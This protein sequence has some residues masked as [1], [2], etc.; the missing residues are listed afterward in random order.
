MSANSPLYVSSPMLPSL[1]EFHGMLESIWDSKYVTNHG[2]IH[3]QLEAKLREHLKVPTAMLF[4]NA[5]IG[6]VSALKMF[7]FDVGSEI[8]TTPL[9]FAATPHAIA[10]NGL[11]P[12]FADV[13][14]QSMTL[15][16]ASV[17]RAITNKTCAIVAVHVYGNVCNL[18]ALQEI[19]NEYGLRLIYDAAHAFGVEVNGRGIGT[20][21]DASVF[22]FHA[23][24]LFNTIEGGAIT[25]PIEADTSKIYML[26]NFGIKNEEEVIDIGLN[27]KM[28]ELQAAI[29]LLNLEIYKKEVFSRSQLREKYNSFLSKKNGISIQEKQ[30]G[31][32]P[33]EQYYPIKIDP[34]IFGSSRDDIYNKLKD[35][36]IFARKYFHPICTDF[37]PYKG[38]EIISANKFSIAELIKSQI[39]CLPFHSGVTD[40]HI[41]IIKS[42]FN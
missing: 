41:D 39:L 42:V 11:K 12:V 21:G 38:Y 15:D 8:I 32:T 14:M 29:G 25:T 17:R 27:G 19:A 24:K 10:W 23:T 35:K 36:N 5:T 13:D 9:T 33:S 31:V 3:N 30:L 26:R 1:D 28:N 6:L 16:P 4:N 20:Y 37:K 7:D 18:D 34:K 40:E 2:P 22:S